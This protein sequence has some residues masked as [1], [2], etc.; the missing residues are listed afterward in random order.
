[1]SNIAALFHID[2][3]HWWVDTTPPSL[4][5]LSG[6]LHQHLWRTE[7]KERGW[8]VRRRGGEVKKKK[9]ECLTF[10]AASVPTWLLC[11]W[12]SYLGRG[13]HDS[14]AA[15]PC[16]SCFFLLSISLPV[17]SILSLPL[18]SNLLLSCLGR[19]AASDLAASLQ[20]TTVQRILKIF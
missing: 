3:T 15:S 11:H 17:P 2:A 20:I 8:G 7:R 14:A 13:F 6:R 18:F 1:M 5:T 10:S 9:K 16:Q 4:V 19:L 12:L